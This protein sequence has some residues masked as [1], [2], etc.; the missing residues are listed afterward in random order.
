MV[1]LEYSQRMKSIILVHGAWHGSWC[2]EFV[3]SRM[4]KDG[5]KV[6]SVD[7]PFT[8]LDDDAA[9]LSNILESMEGEVVLLGHSYGGMVI[10]KAAEGRGNISHLVYLC[11]ILLEEGAT[12]GGSTD[13]SQES[14]IKI[15]VD[16]NLISIVK[17]DAVIPAFY[18]D[19]DLQIAQDSLDLLRPFPIHSVNMGIGEAWRDHPTTYVVCK[20]DAAIPPDT[21]RNMS[22]LADRVLEWD[23]GHSPFFSDPSLICELLRELVD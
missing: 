3:E 6:L 17:R 4:I 1:S 14:K 19:V 23:C 10:S 20:G 8:G 22:M 5:Y 16:E 7:L 12:M 21:Q 15:D 2:W 9:F 13:S 11:A 18:E